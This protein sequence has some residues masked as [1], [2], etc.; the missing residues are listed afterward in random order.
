MDN[1][2]LQPLNNDFGMIVIDSGIVMEGSLL[3]P[4]KVPML[5]RTI[6]DGITR[7]LSSWQ[8]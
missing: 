5:K 3:H 4:S 8:P 2:L 7:L 1:K 6:V